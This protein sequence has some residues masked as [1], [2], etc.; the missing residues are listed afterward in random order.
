MCF[1]P[2][3]DTLKLWNLTRWRFVCLGEMEVSVPM[4]RKCKL[5]WHLVEHKSP[6]RPKI[7][8]L[9]PDKCPI[10]QCLTKWEEKWPDQTHP[11]FKYSKSFLYCL[12]NPA[13]KPTSQ[14]S[15]I[16]LAVV[17]R[18]SFSWTNNDILRHSW[19]V[20]EPSVFHPPSKKRITDYKRMECQLI[21]ALCQ[22]WLMNKNTKGY[23][24]MRE[25]KFIQWNKILW[26]PS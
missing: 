24:W 23:R 5:E 8:P 16:T 7:H 15:T 26:M 18:S 11:P 17:T 1:C 21:R 13:D 20:G 3:L 25:D 6:P 19:T 14:P 9:F 12:C 4:N 22:P 10:S 2:F